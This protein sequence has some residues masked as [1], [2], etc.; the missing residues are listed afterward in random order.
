MQNLISKSY[1]K[2]L[3]K[4]GGLFS[5]FYFGTLVIIGLSTEENTYIPFVA[6]YLDY[7]TPLRHS[8]LFCAEKLLHAFHYSTIWTDEYTVGI[9]GGQSVRM[10]YSCVGYGVM[11]FWTAFVLANSGNVAKKSK[12]LVTGLF[13]LWVLNVLRIFL[14]LLALNKNSDPSEMIDHHTVFNI[15]AYGFIFLLIY[16]YDRSEKQRLSPII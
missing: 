2:Y 10:V 3:L 16:F 6:Q 1:V 5:L 4:F 11:S 9:T 14:F 8:I 12:W 13:I 15:V 7:I